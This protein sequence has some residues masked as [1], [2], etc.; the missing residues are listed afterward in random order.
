MP[1]GGH[2]PDMT[3]RVGFVGTGTDPDEKGPEGYAMAYRHADGYR[4]I[5]DC[6]LVACAD[7]VRENAEAFA[8]EFG[9]DG[10]RVYEETE[11]MLREA[12]PD[13]V[14]VCVP[15]AVHAEVV[16]DCARTGVPDAIHC[17]KP[18]AH[19]WGE[20]REMAAAC[21]E[22]GV[23][24]TVNHQ[25]RFGEPF[26]R[27]KRLLDAGEIG[28]LR[29][30]EFA[31]ANLYDAGSHLFDLCGYLT[32]QADAEWVLAGLDYREENRW[33]GAHNE[34]HAV[35]QWRYEDGTHALAS[36]GTGE[37][38]VGCYLRLRGTDGCIEVGAE[39]GPALRIRRDGRG[40]ER[41]D[42]GDE[43]VHSP[44]SPGLVSAAVGK[45]TGGR[46]GSDSRSTSPSYVDRAVED[47]V[48]GLR[49]G[50]RPELH[51]DNVLQATELVFACWESVRRRS[52]VDLPLEIDD[53]PLEAM[54][55]AGDLPVGRE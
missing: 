23:Q 21:A 33:F 25:R 18:M 24:L 32:D 29:R 6:E 46:V 5:E 13:V 4:G 40:W 55:E 54:V 30:I 39:D 28:D 2:S 3:V 15:P 51:A 35:A 34:N 14:S 26:R 7:I 42:T 53:N 37:S 12:E 27:A 45:V 43:G 41:V 19:T 10:G 16:T 22:E 52:R 20:C 31:E 8:D 44:A 17:E 47:V 1:R 38:F 9:I 49:E 50:R 11:R 48:G 36:T